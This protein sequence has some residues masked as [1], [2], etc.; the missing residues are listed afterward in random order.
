MLDAVR[1][2][3]QENGVAMGRSPDGA[4]QFYRLQK[5]SPGGANG[6]PRISDVVINE[7]M[8][9]PISGEGG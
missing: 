3:G 8:Y 4:E 6:A 7:L 5:G 9:A 2:G 1:F